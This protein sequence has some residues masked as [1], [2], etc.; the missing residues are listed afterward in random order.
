MDWGALTGDDDGETATDRDKAPP[1]RAEQA[2]QRACWRQQSWHAV[3][4]TRGRLQHRPTQ[5]RHVIALMDKLD[6]QP[7]ERI[8]VWTDFDGDLRRGC[9]APHRGSREQCE[10][11]RSALA[12]A[13]A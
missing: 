10:K 4:S 8:A 13:E 11:P 2:P 5:R 1:E 3:H 6:M 12:P 7:D 9:R